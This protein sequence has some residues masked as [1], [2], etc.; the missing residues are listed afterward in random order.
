MLE[1]EPI[2]TLSKVITSLELSEAKKIITDKL[3]NY[4]YLIKKEIHSTSTEELI[5]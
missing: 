5:I 3:K 1:E 4:K 2:K